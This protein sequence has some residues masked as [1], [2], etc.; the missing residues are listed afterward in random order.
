MK[1]GSLIQ[2]IHNIHV[3]NSLS[4]CAFQEI[5]NGAVYDQLVALFF[6]EYQRLVGIH[7]LFQ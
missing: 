1:A 5:I 3:L 2:S 4:A 6:K 7:H